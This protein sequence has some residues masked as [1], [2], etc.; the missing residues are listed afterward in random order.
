MIVSDRAGGGKKKGKGRH[1]PIKLTPSF[2]CSS[3]G[4]GGGGKK[5]KKEKRKGETQIIVTAT[6][7]IVLLLHLL[8]V[9]PSL[10]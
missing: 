4:K 10:P 8:I 5:K 2:L 7:Q 3:R 6:P 9:F 1:R